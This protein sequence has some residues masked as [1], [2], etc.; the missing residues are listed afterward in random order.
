MRNEQY[1]CVSEKEK[2]QKSTKPME[3]TIELFTQSNQI[4][5]NL[6]EAFNNF[7]TLEIEHSGQPNQ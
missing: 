5:S 3:F 6:N 7:R 2:T 1:F 4:K